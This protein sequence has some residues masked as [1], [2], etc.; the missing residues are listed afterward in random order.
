MNTFQ[1]AIVVSI[2]G[3]IEKAELR[4]NQLSILRW[5]TPEILILT[6]AIYIYKLKGVNH[7]D[8]RNRRNKIYQKIQGKTC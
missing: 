7:G 5:I 1:S 6:E 8:T 3:G 4:L 2:Y